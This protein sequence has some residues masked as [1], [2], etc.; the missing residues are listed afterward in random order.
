M[1]AN[2]VRVSHHRSSGSLQA[3]EAWAED[4]SNEVLASEQD[5]VFRFR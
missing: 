1:L 3:R 5:T 4:D 2:S